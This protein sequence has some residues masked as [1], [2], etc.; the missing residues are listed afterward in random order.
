MKKTFILALTA[1]AALAAVPNAE[2]KTESRQSRTVK[3]GSFTG[4]YASVFTVNYSVGSQKAVKIEA[5][6][7]LINDVEV[8]VKDNRLYVRPKKQ[9]HRIRNR[10][11]EKVTITVTA[12]AVNNFSASA[13]AD[14]NIRTEV[15]TG[16][17]PLNLSASSVGDIKMSIGR[18]GVINV[19]ASSGG[20][21]K[22]V[23][24]TGN[25]INLNASSSGKVKVT[26]LLA[27]QSLNAQAF[28]GGDINVDAVKCKKTVNAD[29]SSGGDIKI[30]DIETV[31]INA[32]ASSGGDITLEGKALRINRST[33][34]GGSIDTHNLE[35]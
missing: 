12:P 31:T 28:S 7:N 20:D 29:A 33:S 21:V 26:R 22:A 27:N 17:K 19:D 4:I 2:A 6:A 32:D 18:A 3:V 15:N 23:F 8:S 35:H 13:A 5:P 10:S 14:I 30:T 1:I 25:N 16:S 24:L 34:S 11:V 9:N